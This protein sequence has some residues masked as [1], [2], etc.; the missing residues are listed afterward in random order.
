[1][2][3]S[4]EVQAE[5]DKAL[6]AV[7]LRHGFLVKNDPSTYGWVDYEYYGHYGKN[8]R[9]HHLSCPLTATGKPR[10]TVWREFNG[11]FNDED[12]SVH[13]IEISEVG[14][15]CGKLKDRTW[16]WSANMQEVAEAVFEEAFGKKNDAN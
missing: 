4:P 6:T 7:V 5:Y 1:M 9:P 12:D 11:T 15:A 10:E 8:H 13:G 2:A 16:R 14:C 3:M